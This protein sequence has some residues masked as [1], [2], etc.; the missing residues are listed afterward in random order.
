MSTEPLIE[1]RSMKD[2]FFR[3]SDQSPLPVDLRATFGG[4]AYFDPN[5]RLVFDVQPEIVEPTQVSIRTTGG[6]SRTYDRVA[7]VSFQVDEDAITLALFSS[8]HESWFLPFRDHTSGKQTYGAGR[9]LD[10]DPP[11]AGIVT[12]DFNYAYAPY[13]AY[14]DAYSCAL[15]PSEN[16]MDAVILAGE[17]TAE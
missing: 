10:V 3:G 4:L 14:S 2:A 13:C 6:E 5:P 17:R 16:W 12:I 7:T 11:E 8:G 1:H 9:Y 15:P